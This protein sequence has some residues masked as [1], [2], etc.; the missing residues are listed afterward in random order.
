MEFVG[1][2]FSWGVNFCLMPPIGPPYISYPPSPPVFSR[3]THN[4]TINNTKKHTYE[5]EDMAEVGG[6]ALLYD[7]VQTAMGQL[8]IRAFRRLRTPTNKYVHG[9]WD[10]G[11]GVWV[12]D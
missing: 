6:I 2:G 5:Q 12:F 8:T 9:V 11:L 1:D 3:P 7:P 10:L 4:N